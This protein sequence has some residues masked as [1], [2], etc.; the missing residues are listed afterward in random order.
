MKTIVALFF[1]VFL[2]QGCATGYKSS[3]F[4][5]GYSETQLEEGV[6][7]VSFRGN[8]YT[9]AD[10]AADF[11]LMRSAELT[12]EKGYKYFVIIDSQSHTEHSSYT[13]PQT[14]ETNIRLNT[15]GNTTYG[16]A[17]TNT[18]GG[19]T[20]NYSKPSS[21]NLILCLKE[22]PASGFSYN[23]EMVFKS[24]SEKYGVQKK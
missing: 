16:T 13:T 7:Q 22:K 14:S 21:K 1:A 9:S 8:A 15:S 17:T 4:T 3:G 2:L 11:T 10:K 23:A 18:Y 20:Y 6:Y 12:M 24:L 19:Q 5:G